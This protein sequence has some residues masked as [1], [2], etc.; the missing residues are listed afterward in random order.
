MLEVIQK[1]HRYNNHKM[2]QYLVETLKPFDLSL[3]ETIL[4]FEI[5]SGKRT[6]IECVFL[7]LN[8]IILNR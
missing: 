2:K 6:G 5:L 3:S 1:N 4:F 7:M 8:D